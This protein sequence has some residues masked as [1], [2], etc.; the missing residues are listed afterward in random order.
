MENIPKNFQELR[1]QWA[2]KAPT[3]SEADIRSAQMR[4]MQANPHNDNYANSKPRRSLAEITSDKA[5]A[6]ADTALMS[7]YRSYYLAW[8]RDSGYKEIW[9]VYR[10]A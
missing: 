5:Y 10:K 8:L 1:D 6:F 4:D 2:L 7:Q 9:N 3:P